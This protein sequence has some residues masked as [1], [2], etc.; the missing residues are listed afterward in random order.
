M[1]WHTCSTQDFINLKGLSF[2][3]L[4]AY[5]TCLLFQYA[6]TNFKKIQQMK[7]TADRVVYKQHNMKFSYP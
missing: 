1:N 4:S 6:K 7:Q 3:L 5:F 2:T